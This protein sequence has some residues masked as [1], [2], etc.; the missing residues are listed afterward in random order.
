MHFILVTKITKG[1]TKINIK[2]VFSKIMLLVEVIFKEIINILYVI[3]N[4]N[5]R[6][7]S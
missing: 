1:T 3:S 2:N 6:L 4:S 7:C 5:N